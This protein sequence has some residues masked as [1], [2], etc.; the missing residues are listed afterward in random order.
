MRR[1][2]ISR[3]IARRRGGRR[4]RRAVTLPVLA[5]R[6]PRLQA[7][8]AGFA[9]IA[10]RL[11][12]NGTRNSVA[13]LRV[14]Y[15]IQSTRLISA[16]STLRN[17]Y[18]ALCTRL[19][20]APAALRDK[21]VL[22][23]L[24]ARRVLAGWYH[25]LAAKRLP[26]VSCGDPV[27]FG[28]MAGAA[29]VLV[30]GLILLAGS[31][32]QPG[33]TEPG[34]VAQ[35]PHRAP[36]WQD[37]QRA[38]PPSVDVVQGSMD[39]EDEVAPATPYEIY[40]E[41]AA[42]TD[43]VPPADLYDGE[44]GDMGEEMAALEPLVDMPEGQIEDIGPALP[45]LPLARPLVTP[46]PPQWLAN[47]VRLDGEAD[48]P[49]IA[50]V[51]DDAGVAQA[52]TRRAIELPPPL[53][54]AFIPYGR[55]LEAQTRLARRSGHELL[56]H[57]PMEPGSAT[58]DPGKN[59]LLTGLEPDEIMRRFRWALARFDGYVG[60]NNHMGSKFMARTDLVEPLLAEMRARGLMFLDSRTEATTVGANLARNM[61]LPHASRNV[62]IDNDLAADRIAAQLAEVERVARRKGNAIAI[63]HP[64][65][66]TVDALAKWIPKARAR[67][68]TFVPV[69]AVV[70]LAYG[71]RK[72]LAAAGGGE[73]DG[74]LGSPQ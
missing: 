50:I 17:G 2:R 27:M 30:A 59:A 70:R 74:L 16:L 15:R 66:V 8:A 6:R 12:A 25:W 68:F 26:D 38:P 24:A 62:F 40:E 35:L 54:I 18:Q 10:L 33:D 53:T 45:E 65:D 4:Y 21:V 60:V 71:E 32:P 28:T 55:N 49:M 48:G 73:T 72:V 56:V 20:A 63:G 29:L 9:R 44:S 19:I 46:G 22:D 5:R 42:A 61:E 11:A 1:G 14:G 51:I 64:H 3:P 31:Q 41:F 36:D 37:W 34:A 69:S 7:R 58:D 57:I 23:A 47:A 13:K 67:G 39:F 52:R 43:T